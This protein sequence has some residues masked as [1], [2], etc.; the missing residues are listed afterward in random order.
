MRR[1]AGR[2]PTVNGQTLA[3]QPGQRARHRP[4]M[5]V[6]VL[7]VQ[8]PLSKLL[9]GAQFVIGQA[10]NQ[11]VMALQPLHKADLAGMRRLVLL[12][13]QHRQHLGVFMG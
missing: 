1:I 9:P 10:V 12:P 6:A 8:G 5:D 2:K 13:L 11:G 7:H 4:V 3:L